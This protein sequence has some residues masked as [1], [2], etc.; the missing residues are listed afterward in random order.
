MTIVYYSVLI[1][2]DYIL[3]A[4]VEPGESRCDRDG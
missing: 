1:N 3:V 4:E 2:N